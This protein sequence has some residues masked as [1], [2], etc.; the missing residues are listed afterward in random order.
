MDDT[1]STPLVCQYIVVTKNEKGVEFTASV[2]GCCYF[3]RRPGVIVSQFSPKVY[4]KHRFE[5]VSHYG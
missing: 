2:E 5:S 3:C 1:A 4:G